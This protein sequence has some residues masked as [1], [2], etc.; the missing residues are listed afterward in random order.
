MLQSDWTDLLLA[1]TKFDPEFAPRD[2]QQKVSGLEAIRRKRMPFILF[3]RA[4]RVETAM[5]QTRHEAHTRNELVAAN[6]PVLDGADETFQRCWI[7]F[8]S[9][10]LGEWA[11][12]ELC[13]FSI[14]S[15][16]SGLCD[17]GMIGR[18]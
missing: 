13:G 12:I 6:N 4:E 9:G 5:G 7:D 2:L 18:V 10:L 11:L 1:V 8:G 17:Q 16:A 14:R 15:H 3:I